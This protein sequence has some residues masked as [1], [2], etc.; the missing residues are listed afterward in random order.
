MRFTVDEYLEFDAAHAER[1]EYADG[2]ILAMSGVSLRPLVDPD[3]VDIRHVR[4]TAAGW[5]VGR[6][7]EAAAR[8]E[9]DTFAVPAGELYEGLPWRFPPQSA[10]NATQPPRRVTS[11]ARGRSGV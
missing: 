3:A 1:F 9:L 10:P 8:I 6:Q 7:R 2:L 4:R 11:G 5:E